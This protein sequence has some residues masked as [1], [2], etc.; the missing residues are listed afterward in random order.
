[1]HLRR[2]GKRS[3]A[4]LVV[5]NLTPLPEK[6]EELVRTFKVYDPGGILIRG[7]EFAPTLCDSESF[8]CY[9]DV[10]MYRASS[11]TRTVGIW[12]C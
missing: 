7:N 12:H 3:P 4:Q 1:M 11:G 6:S 9:D 5:P 10:T 2:F 8:A